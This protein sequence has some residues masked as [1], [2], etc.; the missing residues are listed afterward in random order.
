MT[1]EDRLNI[2]CANYLRLQYPEALFAHVPNGGSRNAI[3]GS[4]LKQMGVSRGVPDILIFNKVGNS[5]GLAVELK[6]KYTKVLRSGKVSE[7][8]NMPTPE[9]LQ[10]L[11]DLF[12]QDWQT[13]VCYSIEEFMKAVNDYFKDMGREIPNGLRIDLNYN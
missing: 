8:P 2:A 1:A 10:W 13:K 6:V 5:S 7:K 11:E 9:Q 3:E 4:K 12:N